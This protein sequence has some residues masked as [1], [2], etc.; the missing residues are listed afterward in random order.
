MDLAQ[1]LASRLHQLENHLAFV[2]SLHLFVEN[3]LDRVIAERSPVPKRILDD[4]RTFS[5]AVRSAL[6]LHMGVIPQ[7]L[8]E[9]IAA[10]NS[11]RNQYGHVLDVDLAEAASRAPLSSMMLRDGRRLIA[12]PQAAKAAIEGDPQSAGIDLLNGIRLVTFD[13]LHDICRAHG[14]KLD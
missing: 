8:F 4:R 9:N 7:Q 1:R 13:W 12:H 2:L 5:F 3:L 14:I 6:V 10:L 11:L